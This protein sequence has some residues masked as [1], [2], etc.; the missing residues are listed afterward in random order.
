MTVNALLHNALSGLH[1]NQS[2]LTHVSNNITN[3]NNPDYA[4]RIVHQEVQSH[5]GKASGVAIAEVRRAVDTFFSRQAIEVKG[6][7]ARFEAEARIHDRLQ[8]LFGRPDDESALPQQINAALTA[9]ADVVIDPSSDVRRASYLSDIAQ[10]TQS[11]SATASQ[12]QDIRADV[13][14][15]IASQVTSVNQLLGR[16]D[17]LNRQIRRQVIG[18]DETSALLDQRDTALAELGGYLDVRTQDQGDGT[19]HVSTQNGLPLVGAGKTTL[20]YQ[21]TGPVSAATVFP[22][23]QII[24]ETSS[25]IGAGQTTSLDGNLS[26]GSLKGL[27]AMRDGEL[28]DVARQLGELAGVVSDRLNAVH[29]DAVAVPPPATLTGRQTGLVASDALNF[30]GRTTMALVDASGALTARIDLDFDAGTYSVNGGGTGSLGGTVGSM[31]SNLDTALDAALGT[32]GTVSFSDGVLSVDTGTSGLGVGFLQDEGNPA[33]RGGRGF[34]HFFGLNDLVRAHQSVHPATGLQGA[35]AHGFGG[36]TMDLELRD[37]DGR[38]LR[39]MDLTV[40]GSSFT[41]LLASLNNSVTGLGALATFSLDPNGRFVMTPN[42]G[43]QGLSL[44]VTADNTARA[45]SGV[46]LSALFGLG[47]GPQ[48]ERARDMALAPDLAGNSARLSLAKLDID[49]GTALGD[50]VAT[51]GDNR[52]AQALQSILSATVAFGEA[53]SA[54]A[55]TATIANYTGRLIA[56]TSNRASLA[57]SQA[58]AA[59]AL[60][61]EVTARRSEA[62]GVNLDEELSD[63]IIYQQAYNASARIMSTAQELYDQLLQLV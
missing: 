53:G 20:Q 52:G 35:D 16:I 47:A 38:I 62:Q 57:Q 6:D 10:M 29:N 24:R 45:G 15:E 49:P 8:A 1:T 61:T 11:F 41:D 17:D 48:A 22:P 14:S 7:V 39:S 25:G 28:P 18:G 55:T 51:K 43:Q 23:I 54:G 2:A 63:M 40:T 30:T 36:Q 19:I 3:V 13:D 21:A 50:P 46:S 33:S 31:A 60:D 5:D 44:E 26:G 27:M 42:A 12:I 4:R 56:E 58:D 37:T 9:A 59:V 32:N 34:S